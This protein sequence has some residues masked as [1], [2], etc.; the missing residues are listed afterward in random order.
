M[1]ESI[2]TICRAALHIF[3][4]SMRNEKPLVIENGAPP[5]MFGEPLVVRIFGLL[6]S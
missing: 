1:L 6:S 4:N 5:L 2:T 3:I